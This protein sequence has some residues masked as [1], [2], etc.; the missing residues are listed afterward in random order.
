M[1]KKDNL[2]TNSVW[3]KPTDGSTEEGSTEELVVAGDPQTMRLPGLQAQGTAPPPVPPGAT[4]S[5]GDL[6]V[7]VFSVASIGT[8]APSHVA[9]PTI[10]SHI[11]HHF[12]KSRRTL[13]KHFKQPLRCLLLV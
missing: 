9:T 8:V 13:S 7:R 6:Q 12:V 2:C 5:S 11:S 1:R 4:A 10:L 3:A